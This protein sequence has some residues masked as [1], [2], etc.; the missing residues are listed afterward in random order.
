MPEE[1]N[2]GGTPD[3]T[4]STNQNGQGEKP[5]NGGTPATFDSWLGNQ[6]ETVRTLIDTHVSGL[7]TALASEREQRKELA[8]E[9]KRAAKGASDEVQTQLEDL[10]SRL[11]KYELQVQFYEV[12]A[13]A[14]VSNPKLAYLAAREGGFI[15]KDG[16]VKMD[17]FRAEYPELFKKT[18]PPS[19]AGA[20]TDQGA[21]GAEKD[22]NAFIRRSA[23]RR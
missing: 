9:L 2:Q 14:G 1:T 23:G 22:M 18:V 12:A 5:G 10:S 16:D 17:A 21:P 11:E 7:K 20:G 3:T 13:A 8:K 6:D 15:D 4:N 19:N